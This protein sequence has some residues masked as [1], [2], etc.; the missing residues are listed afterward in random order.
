MYD[1]PQAYPQM[2]PWLFPYGLGGIGQRCH[3]SK[4]SEATQK[5]NLLLYHDKRFQT[6][7]YFP[8]V[9]FN[10]EQ[11]KAGVTGSFL[12]SKRRKWPDISNRLKSLNHEVLKNI[13]DKLSNGAK[14]SP[15]STEEKKCFQLL[16]DLDHVGGFVKGSITSKKYMRNEIWSMISQLGAPS[17]FITLS[18]A[19]NRHPLCL[20]YADKNIKFKPE[21]KSANERNLLVAQNPVAAARFFDVMVRMFIKHVLG[22][23]TDHPGLYGNTVG[24]YG[25]VEQQGR[26]TLHLHTILWIKDALSPQEIRSRLTNNDG[27]FQ[28]KL[29][30]YLEGCQKGEFLTGPM[31]Y[32]KSKTP[33]DV[34]HQSDGI[35]TILRKEFPQSKK[36][37]Y[38]DPTLILPEK[39]PDSCESNEDA[40]HSNARQLLNYW[41]TKFNETVDDI[42]LRSNV[43][44]CSFSD[45]EK[46]KFKL[47]GCLNRDGI[48]KARFPRPLVPETTVNFDDGYINLKKLEPM[49]NTISPCITYLFRCNTDV[50]SL[51]SGTSIKAVIS[52]VTDYIA[53]PTLKTYQIFAT[54]YNVFDRNA[55][56]ESGEKSR[57]DDARK[58]IL[59]IVN[60]LS[61]KME[62]GSPMASMYLLK[63]PDHYTS[64]RFIPFFWKSF[65]ND[66]TRS[67]TSSHK[68]GFDVDMEDA[69]EEKS[70]INSP[71][72]QLKSSVFSENKMEVDVDY[73]TDFLGGG[74]HVEDAEWFEDHDIDDNQRDED[75]S[76]DDEDEEEV[77][78]TEEKLLISQDGSEFVAS[79]K[80]DDYKYRPE[81]YNYSTLYDWAKL[82][83]KIK[84]SRNKKDNTY[85]K[86]LQGHAQRNS[87]IV[88]LVSSREETFLLNFIGGPLP[89]RD[90]GDLEYYSRT[91]LTLFKPWRNNYDLKEEHQTWTEAFTSY[92]FNAIHKKIMDNFNLR[93]ECL[94]ERDDYH[95]ILK[96]QSRLKEQN[97]PS[98]LPDQYDND[99]DLG[100]NSN[101]DEDYGDQDCLGTN[102]IKKS[103][104]MIETELLLN[105][106]GW[107]DGEENDKMNIDIPEFY[108]SV[109]YSGSQ[110]KNIVKQ[111]REKVLNIKK[112]NFIPVEN[113]PQMSNNEGVKPLNVKLLPSEYFMRDFQ[114][115]R[116]KDREIISKTTVNF[117]LNDEQ[118][119]AFQIIANHASE[120]CPDQLKMYLGGMGGTG[121]TRVIKALISM[122]EQRHEN[123]RFI[124]LAPTGTAAALLN[125]STY[126][127][128]LGIRST[129]NGDRE[130]PVKNENSIIKEVQERL[131]GVDYIFI[132][133]VSMISCHELYTISSQLSKVTNEH[134]KPF[135]G[136]NIILAGDFAQLPPING[137]PLYSSTVSNIQ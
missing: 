49:L 26:L 21:L 19:D 28:Q 17:W 114:A 90:Q 111:C 22:I 131:E 92:E 137:S 106:I 126:H 132:D 99:C 110:W 15:T 128:V 136:K 123:H 84:I 18:P 65:V 76:D 1:N 118:K 122:F 3:F 133:E 61:S 96:R 95:A 55:N 115:E 98:L 25:T 58:L 36:E 54:A 100:I 85:Y 53:K 124:V 116:I 67:D 75:A 103:Q 134:N 82:S 81:V 32:V 101:F 105:K 48:C 104:Q 135:G 13:S 6:D 107:L 30:Q 70:N 41:W 125:G 46:N 73:S 51:L 57:T 78:G 117:A 108:P 29:V 120:T 109:N 40:N 83:V 71:E 52:Y 102:A 24:Y 4:V 77:D 72:A 94:D 27:E 64:H 14:F 121:K 56:L 10:H 47:K 63:N 91:M 43:H 20:Y 39:P 87:H 8:M 38:Q 80:V 119:R 60:A 129:N 23:G 37:T 5:L 34:V 9:A 16:N 59:K 86:F 89:R 113:V 88:K 93:Y 62:I 31:E 12:L 74:A 44:R 127:S 2:F 112:R 33:I 69:F 50:T 66:I 35:H 68:Y 45:A 130:E 97:S 7:F 11:L 79:S 42:L